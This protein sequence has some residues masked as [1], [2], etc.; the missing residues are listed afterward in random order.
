MLFDLRGYHVRGPERRS[1]RAAAAMFLPA[2]SF[3]SVPVSAPPS[4]SD[5]PCAPSPLA[6][7]ATTAPAA[8]G[9]PLDS[10]SLDDIIGAQAERHFVGGGDAG[11]VFADRDDPA[12]VVKVSRDVLHSADMSG[13]FERTR[14]EVRNFN[15]LYGPCGAESFVT[16]DNYLCI[17]MRKVP[18]KPLYRIWPSEYGQCKLDVLLA[19]D[20]LQGKMIDAG[21]A[22]RDLHSENLYFDASTTTF[23]AVDMGVAAT[24]DAC[25]MAPD[26]RTPGPAAADASSFDAMRR[27]LGAIIDSHA[28]DVIETKA[29]LADLVGYEAACELGERCGTVAPDPHDASRVYKWLFSFRASEFEA[30]VPTGPRKLALA[31]NEKRMFERYYG[32]GAATLLRTCQGRFVLHMRRVAGTP[33]GAL[34]HL[35]QD[36]ANASLAMFDNLM[37]RG[38]LH[39]GLTAEHVHYE[40]DTGTLFP[41]SFALSRLSVDAS[42]DEATDAGPARQTEWALLQA[43]IRRRLETSACQAHHDVSAQPATS[44]HRDAS[45][46]MHERR[47][48]ATLSRAGTATAIRRAPRS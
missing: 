35:P 11:A 31:V 20:E 32:A 48:G 21:V 39:A 28:P 8:A 9:V 40:P 13:A 29:T 1:G 42:K 33:V 34:E 38:I 15:R 45:P 18:G 22:H 23:W 24:F 16:K 44:R 5:A 47:G 46:T 7:V 36:Y 12:Y 10:R 27:R 19:L 43:A 6:V 3:P 30:G 4:V 37:T 14:Q 25:A 2:A 26:A 41:L 17:R